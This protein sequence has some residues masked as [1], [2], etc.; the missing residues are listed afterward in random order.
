MNAQDVALYL[1][2]HP[3]FLDENAEL[4]THLIVQH[5]D[6]GE[7][8]SLTE[9]QILSMREKLRQLQDKMAELVRFGEENDAIGEKVHRLTLSLLEANSFEAIDG[10]ID[11]H[12]VED[13]AV[14]HVALRI[15]NSILTRE[16]KEF[17]PVS[18]ELRFFAADLRHPYCGPANQPEVTE[19]FGE[20][21]ARVRSVALLPLRR[22]GQVFGLLALGSE[23]AARFYP[24]MGTLYVA[25]IADLLSA[26][27]IKY[28]G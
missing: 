9:R 23:D 17:E 13:F 27:L 11:T 1:Q 19:W 16:S 8:I 7:A 5:P 20:A 26:A 18:E 10:A 21:G 24:E 12:L 28:L 22:D 3:D 14:P 25:R 4:L 2:E 15:W 6:T